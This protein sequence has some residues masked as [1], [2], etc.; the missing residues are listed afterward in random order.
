MV[1]NNPRFHHCYP[2]SNL[3]YSR[4][5]VVRISALC[6]RI[7]FCSFSPRLLLSYYTLHWQK[8]HRYSGNACTFSCFKLRFGW[9]CRFIL[10]IIT[11]RNQ[12]N[13]N[14]NLPQWRRSCS[15]SNCS[16]PKK[17]R[18]TIASANS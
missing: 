16:C 5:L 2:I 11:H 17:Q 18:R 13:L 6:I 3:P 7:H 4:R 1:W 9:T 12:S 14:N 8:Q 10:G 15:C